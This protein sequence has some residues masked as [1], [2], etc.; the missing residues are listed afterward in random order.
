MSATN[1]PPEPIL[2]ETDE[3]SG[4]NPAKASI[5]IGK[6]WPNDN[7][8]I[9]P[10]SLQAY[11]N[12]HHDQCCLEEPANHALHTHGEMAI[13]IDYINRNPTAVKRD[14]LNSVLSNTLN[15]RNIEESELENSMHLIMRLWLMI[16]I[17][18]TTMSETVS[19]ETPLP[20]PTDVS[21]SDLVQSHF[22]P[23]PSIHVNKGKFSKYPTAKNLELIGGFHITWTDNLI[24]HLLLKDQTLFLFYNVSILRR[25]RS[26]VS[27]LKYT[28]SCFFIDWN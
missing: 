17:R 26:T 25:M 15:R 5:L 28:L 14:I 9:P 1:L 24:D 6:L 23:D 11:S 21:I 2:F 7:F 4:G 13:V 19:L 22:K 20:W 16:N 3:P 18:S 27:R 8:W 12:Y 10:N